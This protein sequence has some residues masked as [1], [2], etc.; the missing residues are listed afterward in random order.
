VFKL[1][2]GL[3]DVFGMITSVFSPGTEL[4]LQFPAVSQSEE[5][6]P[7]QKEGDKDKALNALI[8]PYP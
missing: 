3:L 2:T 5:T 6:D 7:V 4:E 1:I 8:L